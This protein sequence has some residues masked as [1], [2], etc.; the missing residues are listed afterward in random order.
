VELIGRVNAECL[1]NQLGVGPAQ[2]GARQTNAPRQVTVA[3]TSVGNCAF[4]G[5]AAGGG[6]QNPRPPTQ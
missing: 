2:G 4:L 5:A 3:P 6:A 1:A